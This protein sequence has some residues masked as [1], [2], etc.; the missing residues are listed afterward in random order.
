MRRPEYL[1]RDVVIAAAAAG[2]RRRKTRRRRPRCHHE[3]QEFQLG[4]RAVPRCGVALWSAIAAGCCSSSARRHRR[5]PL[6]AYIVALQARRRWHVAL[7]YSMASE[8]QQL[9]LANSGARA[10]VRVVVYLLRP[11]TTSSSR[12]RRRCC[13]V[14]PAA[15]YIG[16]GNACARAWFVNIHATAAGERER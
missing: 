11:P 14:V 12:L 16:R 8:T 4:G 6:A 1:K 7:T 3:P 15:A 13:G 2:S 5:R 9:Q 10:R